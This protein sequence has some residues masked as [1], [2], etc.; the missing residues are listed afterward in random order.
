[1][2]SSYYLGIFTVNKIN[3]Q[4]N[5]VAAIITKIMH[6]IHTPYQISSIFQKQFNKYK[7]YYVQIGEFNWLKM[8]AI[9]IKK[10]WPNVIALTL[11]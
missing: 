6:Y 2:E 3:N 9:K 7:I 4:L 11:Y 5:G 8:S 10:L 1:M